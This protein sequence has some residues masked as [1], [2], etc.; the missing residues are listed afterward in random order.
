MLSTANA[1]DFN[2]PA[3]PLHM[4]FPHAA[5]LW[6]NGVIW[7]VAGT[8]LLLALNDFRRTRSLLGIALLAGGALAYFNEPVDDILGLVWHP[9]IQQDTVLNTIGPLPM[10][11]GAR[12]ITFF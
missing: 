3:G 5:H 7:A 12:D 2:F 10:G 9:R 1:N 6:A 8:L 4:L 11:G